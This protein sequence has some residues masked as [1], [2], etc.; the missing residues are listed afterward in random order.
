MLG[1][2]KS[3]TVLDFGC[4]T[5]RSSRLLHGWGTQQV[6]ALDPNPN[7]IAVA[8]TLPSEGIEY[9]LLDDKNLPQ[10]VDKAFSAFVLMEVGDKEKLRQIHRA[11]AQTLLPKGEYVAIVNNAQALPYDSEQISIRPALDFEYNSGDTIIATIKG[12]KPF[13]FR[14]HYWTLEDYKNVLETTGFQLKETR[15]PTLKKNQ[16][17]SPYLVLKAIK[18]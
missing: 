1:N 9:H 8:Q 2:L 16:K 3:Q 7:M 11:I 6:I 4:G 5:G 18:Y 12:E 17:T 14:D 10:G 15:I 13:E